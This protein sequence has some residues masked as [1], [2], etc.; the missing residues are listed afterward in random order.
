LRLT[1]SV[2]SVSW[3]PLGAIEGLNR[4]AFDLGV[5]HY[6]QPPPDRISRVEELVAADAARFVNELR[7]WVVVQ[8]GRIVDYGHAGRGHIGSTSLR[9]G[10]A[11]MVFAGVPLPDL[12]PEPEVREDSVR[13]VQT[14]GG[15]TG[16]PMPRP[17]AS[18]PYVRIA[19]PTAWST[20]ALTIHADGSSDFQVVGASQFPRHWIYDHEGELVAKTGFIDFDTWFRDAIVSNTP[21]GDAEQSP[22]IVTAVESALER[23]LS[24]AIIGAKPPF[25]RL[26]RGEHLVEQGEPGE[27]LFLLFDGI[28]EV[29]TDGEVVAEVG[30]G[31]ILGEMAL[32]DRGH[33]TATL[34]AVTPCRVAVV[35][36]DQVDHAALDQVA[37]GRR[38]PTVPGRQAAE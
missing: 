25:R 2:T 6:D 29:V 7:A 13:F 15:R 16:V 26:A 31:A 34:R 32:L 17:V 38:A 4:L 12:R 22:A 19:A 1:S 8:D 20:L 35:P 36:G 27:E 14:V 21:W 10:P 5:A 23:E 24:R 28:L 11:G 18:K 3:I 37:R 33:R 9:L 30:P